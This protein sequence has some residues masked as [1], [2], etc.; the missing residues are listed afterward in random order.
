MLIGQTVPPLQALI[1][2][3]EYVYIDD[4]DPLK[5]ALWDT[6]AKSWTT[7]GIEEVKY[8]KS[9]R[10]LEFRTTKLAPMAFVIDRCIDYPYKSWYI[11]CVA[12]G[13]AL[14]DLVTK[15]G[16]F[17]FEITSGEVK[18]IE[19]GDAAL[20][21][22]VGKPFA[23]GML[24]HYLLQS[25]INLMPSNEDSQLCG[26]KPKVKASEERAILEV[27]TSVDGFAFRSS[28]W[29]R[30]LNPGFHFC[31]GAE[32]RKIKKTFPCRASGNEHPVEFGI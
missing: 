29:N 17:V 30:A 32:P 25:G 26:Y 6:K 9:L 11:R 1:K 10:R 5:V 2:L 18:L 22:I 20:S 23:P 28:A 24:L 4:K 15:R 8:E 7:E 27:A 21:H 14:L 31:C 3:P 12:P 13:K 16:L 19:R